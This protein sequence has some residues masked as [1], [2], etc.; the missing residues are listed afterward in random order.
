MD[1]PTVLVG[2][3]LDRGGH[4]APL[5]PPYVEVGPSV[6]E[7]PLLVCNALL[8]T[9]LREEVFWFFFTWHDGF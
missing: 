3:I 7:E 2:T 9:W 6:E 1:A 4:G 8:V 5:D